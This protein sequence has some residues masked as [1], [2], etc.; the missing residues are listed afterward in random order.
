MT[1]SECE[2]KGTPPTPCYGHSATVTPE[3]TIFYFGGKGYQVLNSINVF[4]PST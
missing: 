3:G 2:T 1:W 4:D